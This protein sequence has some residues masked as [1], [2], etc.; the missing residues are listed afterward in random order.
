MKLWGGRFSC[1]TDKLVEKY[2]ESISFDKR[3]YTYDIQGSIAHIT[4]LARKKIVT[5]KEKDII[6]RAL[7]KIQNEISG[8]KFIFEQSL[9]DIHMNIENQLIQ[10]AGAAIGGKLHTARSRNDQVITDVKLYIRDEYLKLYNSLIDLIKSLLDKASEYSGVIMPGFTHLQHAQP[11]YLQHYLLAYYQKFKRD[12]KKIII[13]MDFM[14]ECPLGC[15]ALAGTNHPIDRFFTA[16]LLN[17]NKPTDNSIDTVSDRDFLADYL[18]ICSLIMLHLSQMSEEFII[19]SSQEFNYIRIGDAFTTGSSIMPNKKNPDVCEL[20]RGKSA[21]VISN[22]NALFVLIKGLPLSYNRDLQEDK[23]IV[24]DS[25]DT[26]SIAIDIY[27]RMLK[28][29][30]FNRDKLAESLKKGYIEATDIADYLVKK[31][32]AFRTAHSISGAIVKYAI[33]KK[34]SL[35]DI[36]LEEYQTFSKKFGKDIFKAINFN[37]IVN[38]RSSYGSASLKSIKLQMADGKKFLQKLKK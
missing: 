2:T 5:V 36:T 19:W 3:L 13:F 29:V 31:G 23:R 10:T 22:L 24:F 28:S 32:E 4:M 16:K 7:K 8:G 17:F 15:G 20:T 37:N 12:I 11:V 21:R 34:K 25:A 38:S 18:Y 6:V 33:N 27:A 1:A 35:Q 9:E 26:V 30:H 14:N